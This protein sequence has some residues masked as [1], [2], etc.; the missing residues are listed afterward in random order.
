MLDKLMGLLDKS[1]TSGVAVAEKEAAPAKNV[2]VPTTPKKA[3]PATPAV[4]IAK[5]EKTLAEKYRDSITTDVPVWSNADSVEDKDLVIRAAYKQVFGNAHIMDSERLVREESKVRFGELSVREF[6]RE[7]AVSERYRALFLEKY[8]TSTFIELNFKHFLGRAPESHEELMRH[9]KIFHE[10]GFEAEIDSYLDSDEYRINFGENIVPFFRGYGSQTGINNVGFTHAF[11]L[12]NV[13]CS[14]D[15]SVLN[16]GTP[17]L[18]VSLIKKEASEIPALRPIP[19]SYPKDF[20]PPS[21]QPRFSSEMI[22]MAREI[23]KGI[24]EQKN[25]Q[26]SKAPLTPILALYADK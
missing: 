2:I 3:K 15:K 22:V 26:V 19:D 24:E 5:T 12:A 6:I 14:S 20:L 10:Q 8:P 23:M 9:T 4:A 13:A 25:N 16:S 7:L 17:R 1:K 18:Q 11:T 21:R